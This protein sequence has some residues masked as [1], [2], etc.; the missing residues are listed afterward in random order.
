LEE[1]K[2]WGVADNHRRLIILQ[3]AKQR[4]EAADDTYADSGG[5]IPE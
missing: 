4:S 3:N 2:E 1:I 5:Y